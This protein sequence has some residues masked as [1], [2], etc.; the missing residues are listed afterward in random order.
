MSTS[1]STPAGSTSFTIRA[2]NS[3]NPSDYKTY[4]AMLV[5]VRDTTVPTVTLTEYL[6]D[7]TTDNT[8]T[9]SGSAVDIYTNISDIEYCVDSGSWTDVDSFTPAMSVSFTFTTP[10]LTDGLHT[11]YVRAYD[12]AGNLSSVASDT[13][14]VGTPP[15]IT[16]QPLSATK[17]IGESVTFSVTASGTAPA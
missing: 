12:A 9:Y 6:P 8:P 1:S 4:G 17:I 10:A 16:D 3:S 5:I 15:A 13:L 11:I 14:T 2:T 7:P